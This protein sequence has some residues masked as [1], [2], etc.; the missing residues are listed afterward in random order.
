MKKYNKTAPC[1]LA[2]AE[3]GTPSRSFRMRLVGVRQ[4]MRLCPRRPIFQVCSDLRCWW[5]VGLPRGAPS[6]TRDARASGNDESDEKPVLVI[7]YRSSRMEFQGGLHRCYFNPKAVAFPRRAFRW[8]CSTGTRLSLLG[9][10]YARAWN[11]PRGRNF[12]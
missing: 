10:F 2:P 5:S 12:I 11:G 9:I 7:R 6:V 1:A 8:R 4:V 3:D